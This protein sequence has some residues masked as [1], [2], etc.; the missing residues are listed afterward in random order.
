MLTF[1]QGSLRIFWG[2]KASCP[3]SKEAP[4]FKD[5]CIGFAQRLSLD[6]LAILYQEHGVVGYEAHEEL[7]PGVSVFEKSGDWLMTNKPGLGVGVLSADC[8]PVVFY[9]PEHHAAGVAHAGWKGAVKNV[10]GVTLDSMV[11]K[12]RTDPSRVQIFFGPAA[13]TCCYEVSPGFEREIPEG[14]DR[15]ELLIKRDGKIYFDTALL[16]MRM[17]GK[18]GVD[19]KNINQDF[20]VCTMCDDRW[21][22]ARRDKGM[23]RNITM[24]SLDNVTVASVLQSTQE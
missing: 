12:F 15:E 5:F 11:K 4:E 8:L 13:R 20:N 24:V 1:R 22:S 6:E 21:H 9:D 16:C 18:S 19:Q 7:S 14:F 2:D 3:V 10:V 23:E 17:L